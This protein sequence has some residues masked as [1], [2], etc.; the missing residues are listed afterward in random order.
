MLLIRISPGEPAGGIASSADDMAK[1]LYF[2]IH[3]GETT[4][5]ERQL[6]ESYFDDM[7]GRH[8][9]L[10]FTLNIHKPTYPI[11]DDTFSYGYAWFIGHYRGI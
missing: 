1:W 5:G 6:N 11:T 3:K 9:P 10:T 2:V 8:S 4:A 7:F